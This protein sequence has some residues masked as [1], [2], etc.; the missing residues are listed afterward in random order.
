MLEVHPCYCRCVRKH[1]D[2]LTT[3]TCTNVYIQM[4]KHTT[5]HLHT[6]HLTHFNVHLCALL[7]VIQAKVY[8]PFV[9]AHMSPIL[10]ISIL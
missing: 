6:V 9:P 1:T 8:P 4:H 10:Y 3:H 5:I 2:T 7:S